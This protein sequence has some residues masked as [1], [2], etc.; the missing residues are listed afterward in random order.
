MKEIIINSWDDFQREVSKQSYREW[1]YRGQSNSSW[2]LESSLF[3]IL[4]KNQTIRNYSKIKKVNIDKEKYENE[5]INHFMKSSHL[6][7]SSVPNENHKFDWLSVM[8]HYGTPTRMLDFSFSP[9]VALF[10]ALSGIEKEASVYC[11]KFR[12]INNIDKSYNDD[13]ESKSTEVMKTRKK[14]N[15]AVLIPFEPS[16]TNARLQAQQGAFLIPNTLNFSHN[17]ILE[18]YENDDF[19]MKLIIN[20]ENIYNM[21]EPLFKMN[22]VYTN[23]FPGLEGFCKSFESIGIIPINRLKPINES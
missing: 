17:E 1:M 10:F 16:F 6:Y 18:D 3:R 9:Y 23:L 4:K 19:A 15:D 8:Q 11:I 2:E 7:L 21:F 5:M 22:I 14:I 13:I 12:E 20:I